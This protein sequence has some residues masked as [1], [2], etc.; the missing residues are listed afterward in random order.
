[1]IRVALPVHLRRLA[2]VEREVEVK[3]D[4]PATVGTVLDVLEVQFPMLRGTIRDYSTQQRRPFIRFFACGEDISLEPAD[5]PLP[6]KIV[7]GVEPLRVIGAMAG[8]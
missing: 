5:A 4:G 2:N 8:G 7:E 6:S 3:I 1:M